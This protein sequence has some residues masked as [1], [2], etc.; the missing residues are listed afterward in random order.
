ADPGAR[1]AFGDEDAGHVGAGADE[2][3]VAERDHAAVAE[4]EVEAGRGERV[5]EDAAREGEVIGLGDGERERQ[6]E[7]ED[8]ERCVALHHPLAGNRP[9]GLKYSTATMRRYASTEAIAGPAALATRGWKKRPKTSGRKA[10]PIVSTSPTSTAPTSAPR[11]E[12]MPPMTMT[13]K[14]RI[15]MFSPIPTCTAS[16]G[17]SSAPATAHS[18]AP[19]PKSSVNSRRMSTP[20]ASAISRFEAPARTSMPTRVRATRK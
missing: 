6:S 4:N 13:T 19:T 15:R 12:P 9:R 17:P 11:I 7:G 16:S 5:D 20:I 8:R 18:P 1:H 3:R 14:A 10:R 2:G